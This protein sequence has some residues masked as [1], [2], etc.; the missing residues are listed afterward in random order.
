M[1]FIDLPSSV[2]YPYSVLYM[3]TQCTGRE[4]VTVLFDHFRRIKNRAKKKKKENGS[5]NRNG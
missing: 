2:R 1:R 5:R 4:C 3:S